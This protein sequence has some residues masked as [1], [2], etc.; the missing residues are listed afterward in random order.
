MSK[1]VTAAAVGILVEEKF[2]DWDTP[3]SS[4][5]PKFNHFNH[6][7][8]EETNLVDLMSHRTRLATENAFWWR[9][10]GR[11]AMPRAEIMPFVSTLPQVSDFCSK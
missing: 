8:R 5:V 4:L 1:A 11:L 10:F 9:E 3:F 2:L 7:I 6:T